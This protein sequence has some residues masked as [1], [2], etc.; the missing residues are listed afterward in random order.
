MTIQHHFNIMEQWDI[1]EYKHIWGFPIHGGTPIYH[2][3]SIGIYHEINHPA[4]GVPHG[5]PMA[6]ETLMGFC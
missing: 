6:M 4:I 5:T 1:N 2:P 3:F